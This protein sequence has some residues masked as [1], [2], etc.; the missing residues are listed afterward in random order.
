MEYKTREYPMFSACGLNCGLCPRHHTDGTSKCPGCSGE[1]FSKVHPACGVLSCCQRRGL[2]YCCFCGEFPC[3]KYNGADLSDSF[4]TH[5]NQL[6][7]FE[8]VKN[9]GLSA[10]KTGL[11]EKIGILRYLLENYD[12][13]RRKSFFCLAV[14]LMD[15]QTLKRIICDLSSRLKQEVPIKIK[16]DGASRLFQE[17]ADK[18][19]ISL[20]LRKK[21][22]DKVKV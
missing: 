10:Y 9:S 20:K 22:K 17:T 7:D 4:I 5:K 13:G 16:A 11:N 14:N 1:G 18:M 21:V 3:K 12:D 19:N 15:L 6:T 2:E 8:K